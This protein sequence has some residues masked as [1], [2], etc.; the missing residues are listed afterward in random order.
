MQIRKGFR[1]YL[2]NEGKGF[3]LGSGAQVVPQQYVEAY[4]NNQF[5]A[6]EI[7]DFER[8][9]DRIRQ[10][11]LTNMKPAYARV[12]PACTLILE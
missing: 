6:Y 4:Q 9:I 11:D 2:D 1:V 5:K 3:A 8:V 10:P 12:T 7:T